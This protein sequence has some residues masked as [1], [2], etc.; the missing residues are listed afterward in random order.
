M[1][2]GSELLAGHAS[3]NSHFSMHSEQL[4]SCG[5]AQFCI[6]INFFS[7]KGPK[8]DMTCGSKNV[9]IYSR[10]FKALFWKTINSVRVWVQNLDL[11]EKRT[12][13]QS[14]LIQSVSAW[15]W[16][17]G[18]L[19]LL[20]TSVSNSPIASKCGVRLVL[21]SLIFT[22]QELSMQETILA[23]WRRHSPFP[24]RTSLRNRSWTRVVT[25]WHSGTGLTVF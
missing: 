8:D 10:A 19:A 13:T 3:F 6:K 7:M 2:L 17:N 20:W 16:G 21:R 24:Q 23:L 1:G 12:L 11:S 9:S 22:V 25:L 5:L 4:K 15:S 14:M 18:S